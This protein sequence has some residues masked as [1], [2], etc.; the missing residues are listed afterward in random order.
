MIKF[1]S[2]KFERSIS[3]FDFVLKTQIFTELRTNG[4]SFSVYYHRSANEWSALL[5]KQQDWPIKGEPMQNTCPNYLSLESID[6][7]ETS[8]F[9]EILSRPANEQKQNK[10]VLRRTNKIFRRGKTRIFREKWFQKKSFPSEIFII[11]AK[12]DRQNQKHLLT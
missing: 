4:P 2:F 10:D 1:I 7:W 5:S 12:E 8:V 6:Q 3:I 11:S 9:R